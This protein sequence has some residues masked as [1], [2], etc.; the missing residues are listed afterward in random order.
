MK[1]TLKS[2]EKSDLAAKFNT[3]TAI[4]SKIKNREPVRVIVKEFY[5]YDIDDKSNPL[6]A[7]MELMLRENPSYRKRYWQQSGPCSNWGYYV[8]RDETQE[9]WEERMKKEILKHK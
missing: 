6:V 5:I 7:E 9:E 2:T 8:E 1:V 4:I 3:T